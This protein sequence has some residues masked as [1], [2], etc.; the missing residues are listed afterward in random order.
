MNAVSDLRTGSVAVA[1][2]IKTI[3]APLVRNLRAGVFHLLRLCLAAELTGLRYNLIL[4]TGSFHKGF[5]IPPSMQAFVAVG[6]LVIFN[7]RFRFYRS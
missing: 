2:G 7:G 5:Q 4:I 3:L 6:L 1:F